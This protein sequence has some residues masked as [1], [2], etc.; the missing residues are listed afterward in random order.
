M[1]PFVPKKL[2][3]EE[4]LGEK[5]RQA[6][7]RRHLKIEDLSRFLKIRS[8]YLRALEE[9]AF[10]RLPTGIYGRNYLQNYAAA[11]GLK[12]SDYQP[13]LENPYLAKNQDNPFTQKVIKKK[14]LLIF[15]RIIR[16][17]LIVA[18]VLICL[19][20]LSFYFQKISSP[21]EL[22]IY[23]PIDNL[24][25]D[26]NS[27]TISGRTEKE[28]EVRINGSLILNNHDGLFSQTIDLRQ[29]LN[30]IKIEAKKKYGKSQEINKEVLVQ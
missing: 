11:L 24:L 21:P 2:A 5:L 26:K 27:L 17:S 10:D 25:T 3:V 30:N 29:G 18:A 16:N 28:A 1:S 14:E 15:P 12:E 23:E 4:S 19:A 7:H 6:R 20:Y 9:E 8:D 13:Y 22:E